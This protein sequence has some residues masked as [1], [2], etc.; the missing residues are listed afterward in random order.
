L[1][2][3]IRGDQLRAVMVT[4]ENEYTPLG[5]VTYDYDKAQADAERSSRK[6]R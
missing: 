2:I 3:L 6:L 4:A 1:A 5:N